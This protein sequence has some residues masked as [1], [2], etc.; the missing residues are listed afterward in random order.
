MNEKIVK[1]MENLKR[2]K[3]NAV[4]AENS[5]EAC[6][7]VKSMLFSGA[8]IAS[9]GSMSLKESGVWDIISSP[10]YNFNDRTR[11]GLTEEEK[12][13]IYKNTIGCDFYFCSSNAVTENGELVN[14]DGFAN[15]VSSIA[16]G[17][18]KVVMIVGKNKIV[19]DVNE[20]VL[21]VKTVAAPKNAVRL[22]TCTPCEKLG[23][24]IALLNN[25]NPAITDGCSAENRICCDY[26]ISAMQ[27]IK[28][29]ITVIICNEELGY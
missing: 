2:N 11:A 22:H 19:K 14:V 26:L 17:P 6:E 27:K 15:R 8:V 23:H 9:G 3:M 20:G 28:D 4:Y 12:Q 18:K 25:P 5:R 13:E 1:V 24:C 29:R 7:I 21:R 16:F 10:E